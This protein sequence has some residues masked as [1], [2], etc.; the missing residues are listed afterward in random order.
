MSNVWLQNGRLLCGQEI[1]EEALL[2]YF[3]IEVGWGLKV[4]LMDLIFNETLWVAKKQMIP[5]LETNL[6]IWLQWNCFVDHFS[7]LNITW[8]SNLNS[9]G[10]VQFVFLAFCSCHTG[11]VVN[12]EGDYSF[13]KNIDANIA[14]YVKKVFVAG[15]R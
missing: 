6:K 15:D 5:R 8:I 7:L 2:I 3:H 10:K 1:F 4:Y 12:N 13:L 9:F 14:K 11:C